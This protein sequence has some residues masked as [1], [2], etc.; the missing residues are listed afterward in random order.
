MW[1][2]IDKIFIITVD[3]AT[4][5]HTRVRSHLE[6]IGMKPEIVV[7]RS[8]V[9]NPKNVCGGKNHTLMDILSNTA[10]DEISN[11]I[12]KN[13]LTLIQRAHNE[14]YKNVLILE[15]DVEIEVC[16]NKV[17]RIASWIDK[18]A[19][20]IFY[21]GYCPWPIPIS[22]LVDRDVVAIISPYCAHSYLL[23]RSGMEKILAFSKNYDAE[24]VGIQID[25]LITMVPHLIKY[26]AFPSFCFQSEGPGLYTKMI[27][28][29]PFRSTSRFL[30]YFSILLP[31]LIIM[32][33]CYAVT[34][35]ARSIMQQNA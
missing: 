33:A 26:G 11:E 16:E 5:R 10:I 14:G 6:A 4:E 17:T 32:I 7:F 31:M 24:R 20:D 8:I 34:T 13:H 21:F 2:F 1:D 23:S 28:T 9:K 29:I 12:T 3:T 18:N 22:F 35:R 30:E 25:R 15:D 27:Q 19:Y